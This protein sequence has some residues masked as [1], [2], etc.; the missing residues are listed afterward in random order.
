M[1]PLDAKARLRGVYHALFSR[2]V[3]LHRDEGCTPFFIVG[4][5]R[6]GTTLLRR[7]LLASPE[8]YIPP[9]NWSLGGMISDFRYY[10]W[11]MP[12]K[13]LVFLSMGRH[14]T[15]SQ[16]WF[17]S[18]PTGLRK[19]LLSLPESQRS[20]A[21]MIDET[22]RY[23]GREQN[24]TFE[25]W[26][27]KTPM[28]VNHMEAILAVFPEA[29]FIHLIRDGADVVHSWSKLGRYEDDLRGAV[30]RWEEAIEKAG[31]F[32]SSKPERLLE[33]KYEELV[34]RPRKVTRKVC[35]HTGIPYEEGMERRTDHVDEMEA[36][37]SQRHYKN[38]FDSITE[39]NISKGRRALTEDQR[40]ILRPQMNEKLI[41]LGY[42]PL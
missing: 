7:I 9:E 24:A 23:H 17:D 3:P 41:D 2:G 11:L 22:Y 1:I 18:P 29:K 34:K 40:E 8:V 26:G 31:E 13:A 25:S 37:K 12:W 35:M 15:G 42:A 39:E 6:C 20:L 38:V 28:N 5:G 14:I 36:A 21:R 27:D 30:E 19:Q 10:R 32:K 16:R 4:S 33:I